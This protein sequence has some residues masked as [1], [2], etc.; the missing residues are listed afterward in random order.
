MGAYVLS[1]TNRPL[2]DAN[3]TLQLDR[4]ESA[5]L[6]R[7][8]RIPSMRQCRG[9]QVFRSADLDCRCGL[10][11][12]IDKRALRLANRLCPSGKPA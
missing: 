4:M 10:S 3:V 1:T 6:C 8:R 9:L 2:L 5:K 12:F 7:A 11:K